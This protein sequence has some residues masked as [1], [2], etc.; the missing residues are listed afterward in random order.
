MLEVDLTERQW[1]AWQAL[2][3]PDIRRLLYGG[4]KGGG[5]SFFLCV[6]MWNYAQTIIDRFGLEPTNNPPHIG[7]VGRKQAIDLTGTTLQTWRQLIP[8]QLYQLRG[9][10]DRDTRH[11]LIRDRVAID[12]GGLDRQESVNKF[13]SAEYGFFCI[14]QAEEVTKDEVS[15]LRGSLRLKLQGEALPYKEVYTANPRSCWLKDDFIVD[16]LAGGLFVP[17]L[18]ADNPNLPDDYDQTLIE[19]FGHRPELLRAYRDG[20]WSGVEDER[21]VILESWCKRAETMAG[22]FKGVIICCDVARFGDDKTEIMVLSGT[23]IIDSETHGAGRTTQTSNRLA[24][25]SRQHH[26]CPVVVD[27]IGVGA[28]VVDELYQMGRK[29]IPFNGAEKADDPKKFYNR[30]AEAW[31]ECA[32]HFSRSE[33]GCKNLSPDLRK[34]LTAPRYDFRKGKILLESK[35]NI[36]ERLGRS[37]DKGDCYVMGIWGLKRMAPRRVLLDVSDAVAIAG[38]DT[39]P[40]GD[41]VT[42]YGKGAGW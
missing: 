32:T 28:G 16:K 5:K 31:W 23:E 12:Y 17:A 35:D 11:I 19:A 15:V 20:D 6:W 2:E 29:V 1:Q 27:E 33:I 37:P 4:A 39:D 40:W 9:G 7:W 22:L 21:Q 3:R 38:P 24:E 25:L 30:R 10:S 26:D 18:P 8:E 34:D 14:D 13:N 42:D 36:K 41:D